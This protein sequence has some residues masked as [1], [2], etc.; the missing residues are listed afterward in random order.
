MGG[1][2]KNVIIIGGKNGAGK[3]SLLEAIRLCLYGSQ[4]VNKRQGREYRAFLQ[5]R[6]NRR[7]LRSSAYAKAY[8]ELQFVYEGGNKPLDFLIRRTWS[9]ESSEDTLH[10]ELDG[11]ELNLVEVDYWPEFLK[12]LIPPGVAQFFIFDG[13]KIQEI[14]TEEESNQT[15]VDGIK[16]LLG[17]DT[18]E[19]LQ[20]DLDHYARQK[21]RAEAAQASQ[22]D[23][24]KADAELESAR[25]SLRL[26][27]NDLADVEAEM[28]DFEDQKAQLEKRIARDFGMKFQDRPQLVKER[29]SVE[30]QLRA[31]N[32]RFEALCGKLLPFAVIADL[33]RELEQALELERKTINWLAAKE[34]TYPQAEKLAEL[35]FGPDSA[36]PSPEL[37]SEQK[38]FL[39]A[40]LLTLWESLFIPPPAGILNRLTHELPSSTESAIRQVLHE[41]RGPVA[42]ELRDLLDRRERLADRLRKLELELNRIPVSDD[43]KDVFRELS[44]VNQTLGKL[45]ERRSDLDEKC[46]RYRNEIKDSQR[47]LA[48]VEELLSVAEVAEKQLDLCR[49]IK[50]VLREYLERATRTRVATLQKNVEAMLQKLVRKEDLV[51]RLAIDPKDFAVTLFDRHGDRLKKADLSAG[52]KEI[53]AICLLWGLAKTSGRELPVII[54]TPLSRLDSDHRRAIVQKYFPDAGH[55]V[56]ILSTDTEMDKQYYELL[57]ASIEKAYLLNYD[58]GPGQTRIV[59]GYFWGTAKHEHVS[60]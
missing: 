58:S 59:S 20:A 55:Q 4:G 13:E 21:L 50:N 16:S 34:A 46:E 60:Q 14:A 3:T 1:N 54:D 41:S 45:K 57:G 28:R 19:H 11:K 51:A 6:V 25:Q 53:Y 39:K 23:Y 2:G 7:A 22:A 40:R 43:G 37:T 36:Q 18:F 56:I 47:R 9:A 10:I 30:E 33:G 15:I 17:L 48:Q 44:N 26:C 29:T 42:L 52:E 5:S 38:T 31:V 8:V 32:D 12:L 24:K 49:R 35:L 27:E